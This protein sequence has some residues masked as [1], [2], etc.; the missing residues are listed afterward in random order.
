MLV[1]KHCSGNN[2]GKITFFDNSFQCLAMIKVIDCFF[3]LFDAVEIAFLQE[4]A[5]NL[6]NM[7]I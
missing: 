5:E 3:L 6:N 4:T 7:L 2:L 1:E